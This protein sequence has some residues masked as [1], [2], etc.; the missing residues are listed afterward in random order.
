[1]LR[2]WNS[3]SQWRPAWPPGCWAAMRDTGSRVAPRAQ[4][5]RA[6]SA[7]KRLLTYARRFETYEACLGA[8][9]ESSWHRSRSAPPWLHGPRHSIGRATDCQPTGDMWVEASVPRSVR[10]LGASPSRTYD[11]RWPRTHW[12][13]RTSGGRTSRTTTSPTCSTRLCV[14]AIATV[15]LEH[16]ETSIA[17][18]RRRVGAR[19]VPPSGEMG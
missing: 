8:G 11:P 2:P 5:R 14:G 15:Q 13:S 16:S 1:M 17:G 3:S 10:C 4:Q 7:A 6:P 12:Q 9:G 19:G 18:S